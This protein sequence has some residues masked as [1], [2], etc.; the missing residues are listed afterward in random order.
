MAWLEEQI[1]NVGKVEKEG[2]HSLLLRGE[3]ARIFSPRFSQ[4][5]KRKGTSVGVEA[6]P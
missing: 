3:K 6:T 1:F 2:I 5:E 4:G